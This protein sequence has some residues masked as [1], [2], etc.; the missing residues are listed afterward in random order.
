MLFDSSTKFALSLF[1]ADR[2]EWPNVRL[3]WIY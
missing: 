2:H 3:H 1:V